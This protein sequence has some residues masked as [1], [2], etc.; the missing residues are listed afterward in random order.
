MNCTRDHFFT[1][2][3]FTLNQN[4]AFRRGYDP[5]V[6]EYS[7]ESF[8]GANQ[9]WNSHDLTF[10]RE[11]YAIV[12]GSPE[13]LRRAILMAPSNSPASNGLKIKEAAPCAKALRSTSSS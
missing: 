11:R 4:S 10:F 1:R 8:A 9:V 7:L 5:H 2:S 13:V 12:S 6:L 3:R